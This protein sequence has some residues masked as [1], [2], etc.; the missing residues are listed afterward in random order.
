MGTVVGNVE[1][2]REMFE[3]SA[4]QTRITPFSSTNQIKNPVAYKLVRVAG[5]GRLVPATDEEIFEV[6]ETDMHTASDACQSVGSLSAQGLP[7][8]LEETS[9]ALLQSGCV[10]PSY[11]E[12]VNS[13]PEYNEQMLQKVEQDER[14]AMIH[15][16]HM[17]SAPDANSQC[18]NET[19]MFNEDHVHHDSSLQQPIP[20]SSDVQ[21]GCNVDQSNTVVPCSNAEASPKETAAPPAT[22]QR[23]DFSL[24]RGEIC[25]NNLPIKALQETF[26]ATFGR[27]TTVKDKTW[28]KRRITMGLTNSCNV[29]TTNLRITNSKL[30]GNQDKAN[31]LTDDV[32]AT[33]LKDAPPSSTDNANGH[34]NASGHSL[35]EDFSSEERAAKRVR[36]PTRR[37]IE[38]L[39][40]TDEKQPVVTSKD[41]KLSEKSEV[42]SISVSLGKRVTVTRVVSLAG[43]E[44]EV[45]Y[46]S[47]VRRSRPRENIMALMEC[48]SSCLEAK[49][50]SGE[51]NML[52]KEV[53]KS[54]SGPDQKESATSSSNNE[55]DVL[56]EVDQDM[57]TENIDSSGNSSDDNNN[58]GLPTMQGGGLRR[59]HHRAWTLSEVT[60][61]VEGVAKYGAGKWSEI[62]KLSF[63]SHSYR[64]PVDLKDKWRNLL[65]TNFAQSPSNIMGSLKKHGSMHIPM[66]ILLQ[67]R[68]LAEKQALVP[69][70]HR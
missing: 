13:Q 61:L 23:P 1:D 3:G 15:S 2:C 55:E 56:T 40:E 5:D 20:F 6:N 43:S 19:N 7:S 32:R 27:E 31:D 57:E 16:P 12:Q 45:P 24:V 33:N 50:S 53:L 37:Y 14:L 26:K 68:E 28:L 25:L 59:K 46:V 44:I 66:Q 9:Q 70:N 51:S 69:P 30:V 47:L 64:T 18:C 62:K 65:R 29:P 63:S 49:A 10:K 4:A 54:A 58:I 67:V 52:H 38:E 41:E 42:R 11:T 34:S 36:K 8:Q 48:H 21:N 39:S 22:A 60:Q 35:T 17:L